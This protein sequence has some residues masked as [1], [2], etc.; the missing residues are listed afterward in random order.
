[1]AK[2]SEEKALSPGFQRDP[3][4]DPFSRRVGFAGSAVFHQ[5]DADHEPDLPDIS[6]VL[7][8]PQR[9][10]Q[11]RESRDFSLQAGQG[12]GS[13]EQPRFASATAQPKGFPV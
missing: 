5:F 9:A 10:E 7:Q 4:S 11:V 12:T 3:V 1:M 6:D 13:A 2:G 8:R